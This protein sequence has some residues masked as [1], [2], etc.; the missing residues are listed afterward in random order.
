MRYWSSPLVFWKNL[1]GLGHRGKPLPFTV[2]W[3]TQQC[4][5]AVGC[6]LRNV[7]ARCYSA[8][9][10]S[11]PIGLSHAVAFPGIVLDVFQD[12]PQG[13]PLV[14]LQQPRTKSAIQLIGYIVQNELPSIAK[15][16]AASSVDTAS[17]IKWP[18]SL[19]TLSSM[20]A[21]SYQSLETITN[22]YI[23]V[24]EL[25]TRSGGPVDR[26]SDWLLGSP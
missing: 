14:G 19:C 1:R 5:Q 9:T 24:Q 25:E 15:V 21:W 26:A 3:T 20:S 6:C 22:H 7:R 16:R 11:F 12:S 4:P 13:C 23:V 18:F 10:I 2:L 17:I 8:A